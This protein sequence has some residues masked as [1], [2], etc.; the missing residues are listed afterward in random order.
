MRS[1]WLFR[2]SRSMVK[3]Q[4]IAVASSSCQLALSLQNAPFSNMA[5]C[6]F[7]LMTSVCAE[8]IV[9]CIIRITCGCRASPMCASTTGVLRAG[10]ACK[11][12][13]RRR[14]RRCPKR[15]RPKKCIALEQDGITQNF[16]GK[17]QSFLMV[18]GADGS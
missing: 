1:P 17:K 16:E 9:K 7:G 6:P 10:I 13:K 18:L 11:P 4:E 5:G 14:G 12:R 8:Q 2:M 3:R 15:R